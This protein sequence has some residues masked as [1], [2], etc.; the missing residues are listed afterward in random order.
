MVWASDP[1]PHCRKCGRPPMQEGERAGCNDSDCNYPWASLLEGRARHATVVAQD[2]HDAIGVPDEGD[3][4]NHAN[5]ERNW[6][7]SIACDASRADR[8]P[9]HPLMEGSEET[10]PPTPSLPAKKIQ[11]S[12]LYLPSWYASQI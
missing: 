5:Q 6:K 11:K 10:P 3:A 4:K 1:V 2:L 7:V 9:G 8:P 12:G